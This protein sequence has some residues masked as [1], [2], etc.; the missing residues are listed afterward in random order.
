MLSD[1]FSGTM[2]ME[3]E[4]KS[5]QNKRKTTNKYSLPKKDV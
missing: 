3:K 5:K 1:E 4:K 2:K